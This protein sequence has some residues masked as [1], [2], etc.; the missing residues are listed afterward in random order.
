MPM[1]RTIYFVSIL[2]M[3]NI[4][5]AFP[6]SLSVSK[7]MNLNQ[8]QEFTCTFDDDRFK[9]WTDE[10][11][12]QYEDSIRAILYSSVIAQ[13]ADS[14]SFGKN[15]NGLT[16]KSSSIITN[17]HVP[18]SINL[19]KSKE[20]GQIII[21]SGMSPNGARTYEV[22][23]DVYP[24]MNGF[25]PNLS[26]VYNSQQGNSIMGM[27]WAVS[28]VSVISRSGKTMYYDNVP[29]GVTMDN[30]DAFVL[31]GIHLIKT[32]TGDGYILYESEQGNIKAK[33]YVSGS[34]MKYFEVFYPNGNKGVFGDITGMQNYLYYPLMSLIDCRGNKITY[35]YSFSNNHYNIS[36]ISYNGASI[37]FKYQTSRQDP[38]FYFVGGL[39]VYETQLLQSVTCKLGD[40]VL[41]T[42]TM[43]YIAQNNKSLLT[44]IDYT[45]SGKSYNPLLFYYGRGDIASNYTQST[46]QLYEWYTA[47][48]PG[49]IKVVKGKFDYDSGADGLIALPNL[50]P[51]WK[52]YRHS[53]AFRH[54]QN[55]F[56]N[57]YTGDEKIFLYAGL[58]D[59][60]A[61]PMPNLVTEK[62][63]VD[64]I[65]AD[66]EG[67]QE[68]YVVKINNSVVNDKDQIVFQVYRSNLYSGLSK[69][70]TRT[71]DFPTVYTDADGGK[72]I[73]PKFYYVG[74]F[75]GDGK[76]EIMAVSVHQ[77]FGD[78][79]KPSLCY[80]F[81]L[82]GNKILFQNYVLPYNIEFVGT[83]QS[84]PQTAVNNTDKLFVMDYDGDGKTDICHIN[85][86]GVNLYT[87][88]VSGNTLTA[89]K[90]GTYTGLTKSGLANRDVLL[91][92]FNGDGLMDL[93]VSPT[94]SA[95]N[96]TVYNSKGNGQFESS[97][98]SG[99]TRSSEDNTGFIIQD[100]NGDGATD[101]IKYDT[102]GFFTYLA[103]N[104]NVG[105]SALYSYYPS[106]KSVLVPTNINT[107]NCFTQL[108]S[109]KDGIVT[110]FSFSRN[111]SE[112]AMLTGMANSLGVVEKNDY[113][114][115]DAE[116][117]ASELYTKGQGATYPY[118]NI[119]E[120]LSVIAS[121]E[122]YMNGSLIDNNSFT[123]HNAVIHRQGLGFC[124][125]EKIAI[126]NKKGDKHVRTY[127]PCRYGILVSETAPT[128]EN[129][130]AYM[131]DI[132][133][134]KIA[135]IRLF[136]KKENDLLKDVSATT[137]YAYDAYGYPTS[138]SISY[139]GN[140]TV[141][142]K[143]TYTSKTTVEDGYNL[144]F[145]IDQLI[146]VTRGD[147]SYTERMYMPAHAL[148]WP[149]VT[150]YYKDGNQVKSCYYTYDSYGN[151][152][153]ERVNPY[154]SSNAQTTS[155]EYDSYG[156][157]SKVTS[158]LGLTNEYTYNAFG[159]I[160]SIKDHKG[161]TTTFTYDAFGREISVN[162]P[163][164]TCKR[165]LYT[166]Y[167][168]TANGLYAVTCTNTGKPTITEVYDA[169]NREVRKEECRFDGTVRSIG[170]IYDT[171]GRLY[172]E[173]LPFTG[174]TASSWN[175]YAYDNYDRILSYTESS[176]RETTYSY[177]KNS[178]TV[179]SDR[180]STT[181]TYDALGNLL[182]VTDPAGT[183]A[184]N[185]AADG[186]P[187]SVVAPGNI[188]TSFGYDKYRRQTSLVDPSLG[189]ITYEYDDAGNIAK[190]TD[191][192]GKVTQNE[193][194]TYNRL[195]KTTTPELATS[196]TY[197]VKD[198]L[199]G[200]STNNG[201]SK[202]FV[203]DSY[204]RLTTWKENGVDGKWLQKDYSYLN[205]NVSSIKYTSQ[206]GI[207]ATENYI[208]SNGHLSET[209]LNETTIFK[210]SK[211]N[212][213]G[214]PTE[215]VAGD[216]T[217]KYA[218]TPYGLP[219][220]RSAS[221]ATKTYQN[222]SYI[223]DATTSNLASRNDDIRSITE[224]FGY[225]N[226]NR[227]TS[228]S[229][230]TT[231]YDI[232]GNITDKS[233]IGTFEYTISQKPYAVS[234]V[235]FSENRVPAY[236]Q[237]IT[238]TSF[239]RPES[240]TENGQM[241]TF[242][243]NGEYDRV[244]MNISQNG[245]DVLTRY[246]LGNCYELDQS[247]SSVKEKLYLFGDFYDAGAVYIKEDSA[248]SVYHILRDYLG[249][250]TH[251]VASDGTLVQELSYDA[252]GRLR[253]P[254]TH[255]VYTD[256]QQ[257]ILFLGRGYTGHEHLTRF[258]LIN[259]NAR[260]YDP[261]IG[262]FLSPDPHV[263]MP[264]MSQNFNRYAYAMNNPLC[265]VDKDGKSILIA[266]GIIAGAYIGGA[267]ANGGELNPLNWDFGSITTYLGLGIG[268]ATGGTLGYGI[269]VPG[270]VEFVGGISTP[271]L[272]A[273]MAVGAVGAGS[274]WKFNFHWTTAAGGGGGISNST[275]DPE[276]AV[277]RAI[278]KAQWDYS[279]FQYAATVS[280]VI[281]AD[282][283]TGIGVADDVLIPIIYSFVA[284][285][286]ITENMA[287][288][289]EQQ[290]TR[291]SL[292]NRPG[293]GFLYQLV[294][295]NDGFYTNVRTNSSV[296]MKKGE[297]WKY[298]ETIQGKERYGKES[299]EAMNF[300]MKPL[301]YGSKTD[302]LIQEKIMLYWYYSEHGQLP[303]GNK[304]FQ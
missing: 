283:A 158:P 188:V 227:L 107:R 239:K 66:L 214:Q 15:Y 136:Y 233:D 147:S 154:T 250:I 93:L 244:K 83:Q 270:A 166:W 11:Y 223:F 4:G 70:Y 206:S 81:D 228:Y 245:N 128:F 164:S 29:Q 301:F 50:N 289:Q 207:L 253:N 91:G 259:M 97:T 217:R 171:Y 90:V 210:V 5:M 304:R 299:Y 184:Y 88:K 287:K 102:S 3:L 148:R 65:S 43:Q 1:K 104:N 160:A 209:K 172:K 16:R 222:F 55:R 33:G 232:K 111:E 203:Y 237:E 35:S 47:D 12:K 197:N 101:L 67:K 193:Y 263:Q 86:S 159:R 49:M 130:Y 174:N 196:Y 62:G 139:T 22:P 176:G 254:D 183:I 119:Q 80:I 123:Y 208:Y 120:P 133:A 262:R 131:T 173:S 275:Y 170:K 255:E 216:I 202:S 69:L 229:G 132:Q 60:W 230:K 40:T 145:L 157:L 13:K 198:E 137:Y 42:Y 8:S 96:W 17:A 94:G 178:V 138:E 48:N 168:A 87:F 212:S 99:A 286:F 297:V 54:S 295:K 204:G 146:T 190:E 117:V 155:Y 82:V 41:G 177:D 73:Q 38:F 181:R 114:L 152:T 36:N 242:T 280:T 116:G 231:A 98:F 61:S 248:E 84:D 218:F 9:N 169:L 106:S 191:A 118:V 201:T 195:T 115:I 135:K 240:I 285:E 251:V 298:G 236:T 294:A 179:V 121:S 293:D 108:I 103:K 64:I 271:Y 274:N 238:Y 44:Q 296:Y 51:Y 39:K 290:I 261:A 122:I 277:D 143:N 260:L 25:T 249:S 278:T 269:A 182:S 46:T 273:A 52:H 127:D 268:G 56:D 24:G 175:T 28:G 265:Y 258:G 219:S 26:L 75:N 156:R 243:Y 302:I 205:G 241:A 124:G 282:D 32:G 246:Y 180:V 288:R 7:L 72:S 221:S 281:M 19:D 79:G 189:T 27:G 276:A 167:P 247:L 200:I 129:S 256:E 89:Q 234:D 31:N 109:L 113:Q 303:P 110:K 100:I 37:E 226:L 266:L 199:T 186:Q 252:W 162:Y 257:P 163:D 112:E 105:S 213:F 292:K 92:E 134:N 187:Y 235:T 59:G 20:V 211:E 23:I 267:L 144:G 225:D 45:V 18:N 30:G 21:N 161:E 185:L 220:G 78:T 141:K 53:T 68:E 10:Q 194:D 71:Y 2:S 142:K 279:A 272:S 76:M 95:A 284:Y 34:T 63:F 140:I 14:A 224:N 215:I 151:I 57:M 125:F 264:D 192:N 150:N 58:K 6:K 74:D 77:P 291:L 85:E 126:C 149:I 165:T 300:D 153:A